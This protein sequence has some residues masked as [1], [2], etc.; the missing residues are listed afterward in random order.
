MSTVIGPTFAEELRAAGVQDWRFTWN[1]TGE[2]GFHPEVPAEERAK[3]EAVLA[4]HDGPLSEARHKAIQATD[5]GAADRIAAMFGKPPN[6]FPLAW[7]EINA[8]A[9]AVDILDKKIEGTALPEE[10]LD[11][12]VLRGIYG[13]AQAIRDAEG[14]AQAVLL[15]AKSVEEVEKVTPAWPEE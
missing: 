4:A 8:L 6:T 9:R 3:V 12:D 13:R 14:K 2:I 1:P 7:K 5:A 10:R 11:L 15:G